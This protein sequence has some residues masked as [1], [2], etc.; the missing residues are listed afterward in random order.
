MTN[1]YQ[2]NHYVPAGY[3]KRFLPE[4][5]TKNEIYY[6]DLNPKVYLDGKGGSH[7]GKDVHRWGCDSCFAEDNLYTKMLGQTPST[8]IEQKFFGDIDR[9]GQKAIE[10]FAGFDHTSID[11]DAFNQMMLYMST[12]KL[13]TPKG[14]GWLRKQLGAPDQNQVLDALLQLRFLHCAIWA[15]CVWL[16][17]DASKSDT[18]F[19]ISD[20]PVTSYNRECGP[21]HEWCKGF[22]DPDIRLHGTHSIFPLSLSKALILTNRSWVRNPYQSARGMRPNPTLLR[23]AIFDYTRIQTLRYLDEQEVREINFIIKER[24]LKYIG[25]AKE[26]WLHPETFVSKSDWTDFG[27]GYLLMPDPRSVTPGSEMM[28]GY[29]GGGGGAMDD[30]GRVPGQK[31]YAKEHRTNEDLETLMRFQGEFAR[32]FGPNRRGRSNQYGRLDPERDS[33]DTHNYHLGL[34][35]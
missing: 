2:W 17:V 5:Q 33:D 6:M 7:R 18:K 14:L 29:A 20:H 25:A 15:E 32:L 10:F 19:I 31:D 34:E 22:N 4:G 16:I 3:Q 1:G 28:W 30:Y 13:R 12:Q 9:E 24:A 27:K 21:N 35:G 23:P 8:L 11:H 26:E